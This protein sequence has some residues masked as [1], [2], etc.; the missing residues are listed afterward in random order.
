MSSRWQISSWQLFVLVLF[1][2]ICM[3]PFSFPELHLRWGRHMWIP[4]LA[5]LSVTLV[6]SAG[7]ILLLH[8]FPGQTIFSLAR[9]ALG[10]VLGRAYI[11]LLVL[12]L[13]LWGPIGCQSIF[14]R[15]VNA[16]ELPR[17]DSAL[18]VGAMAAATLY[19]AWFGIEVVARVGEV[20][21][22]LLVPL[23]SLVVTLAYGLVRLRHLL[24][25]GG[26]PWQFAA[27]GDFWS[28]A[29][30]VRGFIL[31]LA[32][33]GLFGT[34]RR[35]TRAVL[36]GA[37]AAQLLLTLLVLLPHMTFTNETIQGARFQF[38]VLESLDLID[39][40]S[41]GLSSTLSL[42][43]SVWSIIGW[44]MVASTLTAAA[45]LLSLAAGLKSHR[46]PLIPLTVAGSW[47]A[48]IPLTPASREILVNLSF[49]L[50]YVVGV[51]GPWL[52]LVVFRL[53]RLTPELQGAKP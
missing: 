17:T 31:A 39:V 7:V 42:T 22:W 8:R 14:V 44:L 43:L 20:W 24:P 16:T 3:T 28:Y 1:T 36:G 37:T 27:K 38:P 9:Q 21:T 10:P 6:G 47:L 34:G 41:I 25:L 33:A 18:I 4:A 53:R 30:G 49:G 19:A 5:Q 35:L 23:L 52:L 26:V 13:L 29:L 48:L 45:Y 12:F 15:L 2:S 50:G 32:L 51:V 11:L 46:W 40:S